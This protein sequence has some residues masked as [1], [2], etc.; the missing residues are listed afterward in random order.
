MTTTYLINRSLSTALEKKTPMDLWSGHLANYEM[1][2]IF[3]SHLNQGKLKLRAIKCIFLGD[4]VFN[5]ILMYKDTLKGYW[6]CRFWDGKSESLSL[7]WNFNGDRVDIQLVDPHT[8]ENPG[9]EDEEQD[10][11]PQQQNLENYVLV[12]D[13][14]KRTTTIPARYR[15]ED[16]LE[17]LDVKTAFLHGNIKETIYIRQPPG[18]EEGT[19]NKPQ[20]LMDSSCFLQK[21]CTK[22]EIEYTKGLLQKEFDMKE[23]GSSRKI[24][25]MEIVRDR[26]S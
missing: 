26:G 8:R 14:A 21:S 3:Y 10:E 17:Q 5:E 4:V 24:L 12:R 15:D 1:L 16:K 20:H 23:L 6:C 22:S 19:G 11:G 13:R 9:N 18:F 2:R 7:W 25:G